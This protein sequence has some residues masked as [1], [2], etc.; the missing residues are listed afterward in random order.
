MSAKLIVFDVDGVLLDTDRGSTK[1]ILVQLNKAQEVEAL[2]REYLKRRQS[3]PWG[4][5]ELMKLFAGYSRDEL[6]MLSREYCSTHL[7]LGAL[8]TIQELKRR[9]YEVGSITSSIDIV[10]DALLE[11]LPLAWIE[12]TTVQWNDGVCAGDIVRKVDRFTKRD[13]LADY[14]RQHQIQKSEVIAVGDSITD[15]PIADCAG[16]MIAFNATDSKIIERAEIYI[17]EKNLSSILPYL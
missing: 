10:A 12:A 4:L 16:E 14:M 13:I 6:M 17:K 2:H 11:L 15:V 8:E 7:M 3:G 9:S 1:D 5:P